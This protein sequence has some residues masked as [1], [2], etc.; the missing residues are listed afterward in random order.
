MSCSNARVFFRI[1]GSS[2]DGRCVAFKKPWIIRGW[3]FFFEA[4]SN[5][6]APSVDSIKQPSFREAFWFWL[7]IGFISFGGPAGQ[8]AILHEELVENRK[9]VSEDRF[10]H[11]LNFC[12]L[13]PGPEAQQLATYMG[14]VLHGTWGGIVAGS[15]FVLPSAVLLYGL[16]WSYV[17]F[18]HVTWVAAAFHGLKPVVLALVVAAVLRLGKKALKAPVLWVAAGFAFLA[19][20]VLQVSFPVI[21]IVT[22]LAGFWGAR[23]FPEVFQWPQTSGGSDSGSSGDARGTEWRKASGEVGWGRAV[24]VLC[25]CLALWWIPVV[26]LWSW[27]GSTHAV[28]QESLFFSK[29]AMVTFGGAYAVLPYVAQQAVERFGWLSPVQM[30]D[31]LALAETT[32]GPLIMVLQFVGFLG[33]WNQPGSLSP[34]M[35]ASIGAGI[36]TWTTFLPC[37]LWIF[38]GAPFVERLRGIRLWNRLLTLV[39]AAVVGV[40]MKLAVWL[41]WHLW[42]PADGGW[43]LYAVGVSLVAFWG[44]HYRKWPL[45][46]VI[47]GSAVLGILWESVG[48]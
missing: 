38:L 29:A 47:L 46:P 43:D 11:A 15:L 5:V 23:A 18:G 24:R 7:R 6:Q 14:W 26:V 34:L 45:I 44:L 39:S 12:M 1:Q 13:L 17:V 25:I 48:R 9:W 32:P 3:A 37:F 10:L 19:L 21:L 40:V 31:G 42:K 28:V 2:L 8:I 20:A 22:A 33:G 36:S 27:L 41:G 4:V 30:L 35:A 16:S